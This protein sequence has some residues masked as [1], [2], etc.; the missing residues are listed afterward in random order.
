MTQRGRLSSARQQN[1]FVRRTFTSHVHSLVLAQELRSVEV[2]AP[3]R[4]LEWL[5]AICAIPVV[6]AILVAFS[7][8][9]GVDPNRGDIVV[10]FVI[11]LAA[12]WGLGRFKGLR[13][14]LRG[15]LTRWDRV[16][17]PRGA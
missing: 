9:P 17:P 11:V 8:I 14:L 12:F 7:R 10:G 16:Y 2:M 1:Q 5:V 6:T 13:G 15:M 4:L 3:R